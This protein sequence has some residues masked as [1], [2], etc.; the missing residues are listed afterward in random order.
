MVVS[1]KVW[2]AV[3]TLIHLVEAVAVILAVDTVDLLEDSILDSLK[4]YCSVEGT[5]NDR[6]CEKNNIAFLHPVKTQR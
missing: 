4:D 3:L 1:V 6:V 5:G 2:R